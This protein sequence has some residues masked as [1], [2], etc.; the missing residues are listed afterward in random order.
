[1][2]GAPSVAA[3]SIDVRPLRAADVAAAASSSFDTF[4]ALDASLGEPAHERTEHDRVR[5]CRAG[6]SAGGCSTGRC[7]LRRPRRP[8]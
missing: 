8:P 5:G 3:V 4:A 2:D 6:A 1:V 7:P